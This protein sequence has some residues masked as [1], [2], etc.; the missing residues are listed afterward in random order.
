MWV[1][2]LYTT[3]DSGIVTGMSKPN[4]KPLLGRTKWKDLDPPRIDIRKVD[5][6]LKLPE[7]GM[8]PASQS[9]EKAIE[10]VAKAIGV[11]KENPIKIISTPV[12]EVRAEYNKIFHLVEKRGED[13]ER[14]ANYVLPA[15]KKPFEVWKV[16]YDD[17]GYRHRYI[18]LF[19]GERDL[20][21]TVKVDDDGSLLWN[22]MQD[23]HAGMNRM[24]IG[25]LVYEKKQANMVKSE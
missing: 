13:R 16:A 14:Y 7:P 12:E 9:I 6:S 21:V 15:L 24:R 8:L 5:A 3:V 1:I 4:A 10:I 20:A 2:E 22:I 11:S 17:G 19:Q 23:D 18:G 25:E